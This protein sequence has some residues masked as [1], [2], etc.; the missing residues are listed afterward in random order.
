MHLLTLRRDGNRFMSEFLHNSSVSLNS[1]DWNDGRAKKYPT[2]V[3]RIVKN[4]ASDRFCDGRL[5]PL[6]NKRCMDMLCPNF[7]PDER[8][9]VLDPPLR[10]AI[11]F[12]EVFVLVDEGYL[13][14]MLM[15]YV[16]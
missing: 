8:G 11:R 10:P 12:W 2:K 6:P 7:K 9:C 14:C 4:I 5:E 1:W 15:K 3:R 13:Q 16:L